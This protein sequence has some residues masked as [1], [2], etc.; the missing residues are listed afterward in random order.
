MLV[1]GLLLIRRPRMVVV[2]SRSRVRLERELEWAERGL[3]AD[4]A[5]CCRR[6]PRRR[7]NV[8]NVQIVIEVDERPAVAANH[9]DRLAQTIR[10]VPGGVKRLMLFPRPTGVGPDLEPGR[11]PVVAQ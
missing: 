2:S 10:P 1:S 6:S 11:I 7:D 3:D 5:T 4:R 8:K 9:G